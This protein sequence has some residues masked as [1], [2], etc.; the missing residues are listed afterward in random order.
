MVKNLFAATDCKRNRPTPPHRGAFTLVELLVVIAI[1]GI[2][3]ALLL[4][5]VQAAREA[6]RRM[7]CTNNV[8]NV[9]LATLNYEAANEELPPGGIHWVPGVS[10]GNQGWERTV[11]LLA[12]ILPYAEDSQLHDL[13]DF[14]KDDTYLQRVDPTDPNSAFISS[15]PVSLYLCPS[16]TSERIR[17]TTNQNGDEQPLAMTNYIGSV[18]SAVI[19][20]GNNNCLCSPGITAPYRKPA[21][22]SGAIALGVRYGTS[23]SPRERQRE[24]SGVFSRHGIGTQLRH[25]TDGLSKTIFIGEVRP[26]CSNHVR[27]GGWIG[28]NN[29]TG[30]VSTVI[31]INYDTCQEGAADKCNQPCNWSMSWG[32]KSLHPSG[33]NFG[34]GDGSVQFL[35]EDI[36]HSTVYQYLGDKADDNPV[37]F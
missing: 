32:F 27:N 11:G 15:F 24:Y 2:L 18:G 25:I 16:D 35:T 12:R 19:G 31:P 10:G 33:A 26:D 34:L 23:G 13:I 4:P 14:E 8:K 17:V 28:D 37:S 5:A 1:I 21:G 30:V 9:V 3:V 20:L 22:L 29:G 7:Q 6:A 36:E